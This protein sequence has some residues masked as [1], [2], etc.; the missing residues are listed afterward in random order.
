MGHLDYSG[1]REPLVYGDRVFGLDTSCCVGGALTGLLLPEFRFI[2]VP[3][4]A[5]YWRA[6]RAAFP[7]AP[8]PAPLP[9]YRATD[10]NDAGN[11]LLAELLALIETQHTKIMVELQARPGFDTLH[12]RDQDKA[13]AELAVKS[14]FAWLL[15]AARR[16]PLDLEK[17]RE[18]FRNPARA[19]ALLK[20]ATLNEPAPDKPAP[21]P[22]DNPDQPLDL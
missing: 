20:R 12:P 18:I 4:H 17:M 10:W 16:A 15:F 22:L 11:A 14:T 2:S 9:K 8:K 13:Y 3:S 6:T 19:Q 7:E 1:K 21:G 5:N